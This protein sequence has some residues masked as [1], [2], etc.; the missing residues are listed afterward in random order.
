MII[1]EWHLLIY[2]L[3]NVVIFIW[4]ITRNGEV[5][6]LG[7]DRLWATMLFFLFFIIST[8]I[9]GGIFWW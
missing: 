7:S 1:I 3:V 2:I 5:G 6:F 4:A 9:Y 8:L